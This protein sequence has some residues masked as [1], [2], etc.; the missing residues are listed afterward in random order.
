MGLKWI[1]LKLFIHFKSTTWW[2]FWLH[3]DFKVS[4][5]FSTARQVDRTEMRLSGSCHVACNTVKGTGHCTHLDVGDTGQSEWRRLCCLW[6]NKSVS[7]IRIVSEV[8]KSD[9]C[10]CL[11]LSLKN[12]Y[13]PI[14]GQPD[15]SGIKGDYFKEQARFVRAYSIPCIVFGRLCLFIEMNSL[16]LTSGP[17]SLPFPQGTMM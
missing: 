9:D 14:M 17:S 16:Q 13:S 15:Q 1:S 4:A 10:A 6:N 2:Y 3:V 11:L 5:C 12:N 8:P 7:R